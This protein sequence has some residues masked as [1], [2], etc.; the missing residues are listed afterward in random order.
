M[1]IE[2]EAKLKATNEIKKLNDVIKDLQTRIQDS[3]K[4]I[5]DYETAFKNEKEA[6]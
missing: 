5:N 2:K 4:K 1:K 6:K 3:N